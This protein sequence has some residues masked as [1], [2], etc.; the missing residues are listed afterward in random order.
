MRVQTIIPTQ[1]IDGTTAIDV[2]GIFTYF[3]LAKI[4]LF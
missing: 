1:D 3:L 4:L 2:A